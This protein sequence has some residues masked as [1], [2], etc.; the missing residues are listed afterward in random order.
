MAIRKKSTKSPPVLSHEFIVQNHA[1][2][3]SCVAMVFLL[4][5]MFEVSAARGPQGQGGAGQGAG[6]PLL[7]R[8]APRRPQW[9][10][11]ARPRRAPWLRPAPLGGARERGGPPASPPGCGQLPRGC[12]ET[13]APS[14]P[15][16][17]CQLPRGCRE[18]WGRPRCRPPPSPPAPASSPGGAGECGGPPPSP[19]A[20]PRPPAA[21]RS[22][23]FPRR[24]TWQPAR[25][26]RAGAAPACW[27]G[28]GGRAPGVRGR[29][30][31][32]PPPH[33]IPR[34]RRRPRVTPG[35]CWGEGGTLVRPGLEARRASRCLLE[36]R[37]PLG[38]L[39]ARSTRGVLVPST[40]AVPGQ[41]A[42][43]APPTPEQPG[44]AGSKEVQRVK[45]R[46]D[47]VSRSSSL[48][49]VCKFS[50]HISHVLMTSLTAVEC[51]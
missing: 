29:G 5:L 50:S 42:N 37:W 14:Q 41:L 36:G 34:G 40:G 39:K 20:R 38:T 3:V 46:S 30:P 26:R 31:A 48:S 6:L 9:C 15:P 51:G 4:G 27:L 35:G 11:P 28:P 7:A 22:S 24:V 33:P 13:W 18:T 12:Q 1:D 19:P 8:R 32:D 25:G 49:G 23:W 45:Q 47:S 10:P 21:P 2:I 17:C 44:A 43:F 16:G